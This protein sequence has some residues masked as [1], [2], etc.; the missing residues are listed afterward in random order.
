MEVITWDVSTPPPASC[1]QAV[2][3]VGNFDGVHK[4]HAALLKRLSRLKDRIGSSSLVASFDPPPITLLRP[5]LH[6][7]PLTTLEQKLK[8]LS[9]FQ[10]DQV[11]VFETNAALLSLSAAAF[12]NQLLVDQLQIR[13][14]VEGR[15][16]FFGRDREGTVDLL[17]GWSA[18][19][20]LP[21][22]IVHDVYRR[23]RRVSSSAIREALKQGDVNWAYSGLGRYYSVTGQVI[24]GDRRGARIGFPTAN[25]A[26][27]PT[28]IPGSGVYAA[29]AKIG[30]SEHA[31]AVNIGPNPTFG[32][33]RFKVEAHLL[34]FQG[35]LYGQ[36]I[37]LEFIA[38]M[39]STQPFDSLQALQR[40]LAVDIAQTK[41]IV[42]RA[43]KNKRGRMMARQD[44]ASTTGHL[45]K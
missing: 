22:E 43:N 3:S 37:S 34:D 10:V 12:W 20:Q 11:L 31:A 42:E 32:V 6:Y 21:L 45:V 39:R 4:G 33:E 41:E 38:R 29:F 2:I 26:D 15:N 9:A 5:D 28:L 24:Q 8:L 25:L 18:E 30:D 1:R 44:A 19:R 27:I 13:G 14:M 35:D 23:R 7:E 16:F 17:R 36:T 40:Q